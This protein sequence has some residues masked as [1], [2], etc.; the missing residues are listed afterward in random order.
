MFPFG[1]PIACPAD[2]V[3][4]DDTADPGFGLFSGDL[5]M[6]VV[7]IVVAVVAVIVA[8]VLIRRR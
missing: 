7:L 6:A 4:C 5:F 8:A 3:G 2:A 1:I